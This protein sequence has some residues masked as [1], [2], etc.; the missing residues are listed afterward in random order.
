MSRLHRRIAGL[1]VVGLLTACSS[2]M[3]QSAAVPPDTLTTA[4]A[5]S[6]APTT[7]PT[8]EPAQ[9]E[10]PVTAS[11]DKL[12]IDGER[13]AALGDPNA[14]ITVVEFSDYG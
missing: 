14:P 2:T 7:E 11:M 10:G 12:N 3:P 5:A 1:I 9:S 4:T 6:V 8:P 13:Y